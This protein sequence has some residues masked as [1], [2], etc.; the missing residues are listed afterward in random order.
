MP[1]TLF[2]LILKFKPRSVHIQM[3]NHILHFYI[4]VNIILIIT[5]VLFP[6]LLEFVRVYYLLTLILH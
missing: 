1:P 4:V 6:C 5:G 3:L 2:V